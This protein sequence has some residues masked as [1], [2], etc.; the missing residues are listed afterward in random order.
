MAIATISFTRLFCHFLSLWQDFF[1]TLPHNFFVL[2]QSCFQNQRNIL[3][4][5]NKFPNK[6]SSMYLE[7]FA[8]IRQN[9]KKLFRQLYWIV[10]FSNFVSQSVFHLF[11]KIR[12]HTPPPLFPP[13]ILCGGAGAPPCEKELVTKLTGSF[14]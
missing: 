11:S 3:F 10:I 5:K 1:Q 12:I 2:Q 14:L 7:F 6:K 4:R 13:P 9:Y 8:I